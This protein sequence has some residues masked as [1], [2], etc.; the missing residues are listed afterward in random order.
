MAARSTPE[1]KDK[2]RLNTEP[3]VRT[4]GPL[5][6]EW[7][8]RRRMSQ[9]DLASDAGIST[10]HLSFLETGRSRPSRQMLLRLAACLEV[11][12][13]DRNEL[14]NAAGFSPVFEERSLDA[15]PL[16]MVR[17]A[18]DAVL[19]AHDPNP[20]LAV[21]R[22]WTMVAANRAV[23]HLFSGGEPLLLRPPVNIMRLLLHP[24]GMASRIVNLPQWRSHAIG[25]LRRRIDCTGDSGLID[26]LDEIREYPSVRA[27][28]AATDTADPDMVA[29][30]LRLATMDGIMSF[31]ETST[32]FATPVDIT[33]SELS[34]EAF[35]PADRQTAEAMRI[36]ADKGDMQS[37]P[38][39]LAPA[40][41]LAMMV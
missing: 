14:L 13:R 10:K 40:Q 1:R 31:Y 20:A 24:A 27:N 25:R 8:I 28:G 23:A 22:R 2:R 17:R 11:P 29:V 33:V 5:L 30:P 34:I 19:A 26:L 16:D 38:R 35:L 4:P 39:P 15:P 36:A 21:D 41:T 7:R 18:V 3:S 12:L 32:L 37:P 9:F 6:R